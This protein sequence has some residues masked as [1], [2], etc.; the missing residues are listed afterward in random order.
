MVLLL[1]CLEGFPDLLHHTLKFSY[2][3]NHM[4]YFDYIWYDGKYR[5]KVLYSNT[6]NH[7]YGLEIKVT[8][9]ELLW[10]KVLL[11]SF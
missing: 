1:A 6:T 4:M 11:K 8:Y 10:Y 5:L 9:L 3:P 2:F 7:T